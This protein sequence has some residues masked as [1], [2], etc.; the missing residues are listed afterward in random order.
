MEKNEIFADYINGSLPSEEEN[1]LFASMSFDEDLRNDFR[2][3]II[4]DKKLKEKAKNYIPPSDVTNSIYAGL[5]FTLAGSK[6]AAAG[7]IKTA[8]LKTK[9]FA[10]LSTGTFTFFLTYALFNLVNSTPREER[11]HIQ[12]SGSKT[13][14][15]QSN[16]DTSKTAETTETM[17]S[18]TP[19]KYPV[20]GNY[21]ASSEREIKKRS[22]L[23][24]LTLNDGNNTAPIPVKTTPEPENVIDNNTH[25]KIVDFS[26]THSTIDYIDPVQIDINSANPLENH[27][28]IPVNNVHVGLE[29]TKS[30]NLLKGFSLEVKNSANWSLKKVTVYPSEIPNFQNMDLSVMY[31]AFDNFDLGAEI[32]Q[33]SFF[34]DYKGTDSL[35]RQYTIEQNPNLTSYGLFFR[36]KPL[37]YEGFSALL[38][39]GVSAN[40]YGIISRMG[41]GAEYLISGNVG[42][43]CIA[44]YSGFWYKHKSNTFYN[45][46]ISLVYGINY[47][48]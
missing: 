19:K 33:E 46:K 44:L 20:S 45:D 27:N 12:D 18:G 32:K 3:F 11:A 17:L 7:I 16:E 36:Y 5:G 31:N 25:S 38:H 42:I 30:L 24:L 48:F 41:A 8:F 47:K 39:C 34:L 29:N 10:I 4:I 37:E 14:V 22:R 2:R 1:R 28:V 35:A 26:N 21:A 9:L 15:M 43:N 13:E 23:S 40:N 6:A